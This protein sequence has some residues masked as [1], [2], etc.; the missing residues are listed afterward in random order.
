MAQYSLDDFNDVSKPMLADFQDNAEFSQPI[1]VTSASSN[2]NIAATTALLN[3]DDPEQIA[4]TFQNVSSEL[5]NTGRSQTQQDV[6]G[7]VAAEERKGYGIAT[8]DLLTNPNA[9]DEWKQ[10]ALS[11]FQDENNRLL[12]SRA[13]LATRAAAKTVPDESHESA[14]LRG[15]YAAGIGEVMDYQRQKQKV[16]N[17][18]QQRQK[19]SSSASS[20]VGM[21]ENM[22]PGVSGAKQA[23]LFAGLNDSSLG[24]IASLFLPGSSKAA[25]SEKFN[26]L[27]LSERA[28]AMNDILRVVGQDGKTLL[29]PEEKDQA[30]M[31]VFQQ[32]INDGSYSTT[33]ETIDNV[34]GVLDMVGIGSWARKTLGI[35]KEAKAAVELTDA[36][37]GWQSRM[38]GS[39]VQPTTPVEAIKDANP[40]QAR[41]LFNVAA[42][43][44]TGDISKV[45][46]GTDKEQAIAGNLSPQPSVPTNSVASKV[47]R[48]ELMDDFDY[49][50]DASVLDFVDN[51]SAPHLSQVEKRALNTNVLNDFRNATGLVN[52]KEMTVIEQSAAD[53]GLNIKATYGAPDS[54]WSSLNEA[55]EQAKFALRK[56]GIG[57]EDLSVLYRVGDEYH[58]VPMSEANKVVDEVGGDFLLQINQRYEYNG[59]DMAADSFQ[60]M[61]VSSVLN[62]FNRTGWL[63]GTSGQ[64]SLLSQVLDPVS[65]FQPEFLKGAV[66][67]DLKGDALKAKL[68]NT[69]QPYIDIVKKLPAERKAVV[70]N[71]IMEANAKGQAFNTAALRAKGL[72][73][74]EVTALHSFKATQDT[75]HALSNRDL[76]KTYKARGFSKMVDAENGM[77]ILVKPVSRGALKDGVKV[78]DST[79]DTVKTLSRQELDEL[80]SVEGRGVVKASDP[81][82]IDSDAIQ[83]VINHNTPGGVYLRGLK[84]SDSL[85]HYRK[86]YYAVRYNNPH[87]IEKQVVDADGFPIKDEYGE[88]VWKAVATAPDIPSAERAMARYRTTGGG[89]Y[90]RR[91]DLKGEVF[92]KATTQATSAGGLSSQRLRGK[93]LEDAVGSNTELSGSHIESPAES[94][95]SSISAISNRISYRDWLETS[96]QRLLHTFSDV[97]P[98]RDGQITYPKN[99][100]DIKGTSKDAEDARA[101]FEYLRAMENGYVNMIDDGYKAVFNFAAEEVG[102]R[103]FGTAENML[104][105]AGKRGVTGSVKQTVGVMMLSLAPLRQLALQTFQVGFLSLRFPSYVTRVIDDSALL[106]LTK[107][108]P[109]GGR[110]LPNAIFTTFGRNKES[111]LR[112]M[113]DMTQ[114]GITQGADSHDIVR[115]L[116]T[117]TA[118][119]SVA[120]M[121]AARSVAQKAASVGGAAIRASRKIGFDAGE[122]MVQAT[123]Y[124]AHYDAATKG[125]TK[126]IGKAEV[127][128]VSVAARQFTG[129]FGRSGQ[130][131]ANQNTGA[132]FTQFLQVP[133]K[134]SQQIMLNRGIPLSQRLAAI[135]AVALMGGIGTETIYRQ[136]SDQLPEDPAMRDLITNGIVSASANAIMTN[137]FGE[138]SDV[139]WWGS[140]NPFDPAGYLKLLTNVTDTGLMDI[141]SATPAGSLVFGTNPRITN[142]I[143]SAGTLMGLTTVADGVTT[144]EKWNQLWHDTA[145][146]SSGLSSAYKARMMLEYHKQ[147][148]AQGGERAKD[149]TTPEAMAQLFGFQLQE[150]VTNWAMISKL[151]EGK[152]DFEDDVKA[153]FK[154]HS[155]RLSADGTQADQL[156]YAVK[157]SQYAMQIYKDNPEARKVWMA[158]LTKQVRSGDNRVLNKI[159]ES[160]GWDTEEH[161]LANI[162][163][164]TGLTTEQ[165]DNLRSIVKFQFD[166]RKEK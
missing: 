115:G 43:D 28:Q 27:P 46:Y 12:S 75:L 73:K 69:A 142:L 60:K 100:S 87:F 103:G 21:A 40:A 39:D 47:S 42:K 55:K 109:N 74:D 38:V 126:V 91:G 93:R 44:T 85:L 78:Y 29:L 106:M 113:D 110:D 15:V 157:L 57:D 135:P 114:S 48:P 163:K 64:G 134:Y 2:N 89:E 130:I 148:S 32:I 79:T 132:M 3:S 107:M 88:D 86:G 144:A 123:S 56:Y 54:G 67:G 127:D 61:G 96:K 161:V 33:D 152:K 92:E 145:G 26:S 49:M 41:D 14:D 1:P 153:I 166:S 128:S 164:A 37:R 139:D 53:G 19:D 82:T 65:L 84:D 52:R 22:V 76:I 129:N 59:G 122:Y 111:F 63:P 119:A 133:I 11:N 25:M 112:M 105:G 98:K 90:R 18:M 138:K 66:M 10:Q 101:T 20:W 72:S 136:F 158:E 5:T 8:A 124:M 117:S 58:S 99:V 83:F 6:K 24:T 9:A 50:P 143:K 155:R 71:A 23:R 31:E 146:L 154:D 95:M 160:A 81:L 36:Q 102:I 45:M 80:Y 147:Y 162:D 34:F 13:M 118:D 97:M 121:K 7:A 51:T 4:S 156:E 35:G 159:L 151:A 30:N 108:T 70:E 165:R 140:V 68:I 125:L 94:M 137:L 149:V 150:G 16:Y 104:R 120:S 77:D 62:S 116:V 131:A 141:I 17:E